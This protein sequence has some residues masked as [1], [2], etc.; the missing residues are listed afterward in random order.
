M[1]LTGTVD[2]EIKNIEIKNELFDC[3]NKCATKLNIKR[4]KL[5][6]RIFSYF[7]NKDCLICEAKIEGYVRRLLY[8]I[9]KEKEAKSST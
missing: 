2:T 5:S 1:L 7:A 9:E 8:K 6:S 4:Q 3:I